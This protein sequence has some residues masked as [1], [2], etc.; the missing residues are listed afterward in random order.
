M[1]SLLSP[2]GPQPARV[3]WVRRLVVLGVPLILIIIIAVSCSGGS[4]TPSASANGAGG[5]PSTGSSGSPGGVTDCTPADL[6]AT[7]STSEQI[8]AIGDQP[9]FTGKLTNVSQRTCRLTTAPS[10]E[11]WT[12]TSGAADWWTTGPS[13]G[14]R[15]SDVATT[16]MLAPGSSGTVSITWNGKRLEPGC[17]SGDAAS[18]GEYVLHAK[19]DGVSAPQVVFAFHNHA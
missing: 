9:V 5:S 14:C 15:S 7:I 4:K 1:S 3:Y 13:V 19:L 10:D 8:Y 16:K 2:V 11:V 6:S 17:T 18:P 12:V